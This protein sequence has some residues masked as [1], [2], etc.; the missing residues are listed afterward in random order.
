MRKSFVLF[1]AFASITLYSCK[2]RNTQADE[3]D[4]I[5]VYTPMLNPEHTPKPKRAEMVQRIDTIFLDNS[6]LESYVDNIQQVRFTKDLIFVQA[7][8]VLF[9]FD[10]NGKYVRRILKKG[11]GH[12]EYLDLSK[13]DIQE[14]KELI[15]V[16]DARQGEFLVYTFG[17][18]FVRRF[19]A[20]SFVADFVV[21]PNGHY[22][23]MN[24]SDV[25]RCIR[26]L[27]ETDENG[28]YLRPLYQIPDYFKHISISPEYLVHIN[29]SVIGC[30][31]LEENDYIFHYQNDTL[32]PVYKIKPDI[33]M[34]RDIMEDDRAWDDSEHEYGKASYWETD[35]Y[36]GISLMTPGETYNFMIA[37]Y[38]KQTGKTYRYYLD[39]LM[40]SD[41]QL[42][43]VP[44]FRFCYKGKA[45]IFY[46]Y[47]IISQSEEMMKEFPTITPD[48]NPVLFFTTLK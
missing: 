38:N 30:Q 27:F 34:S 47:D 15:T 20:P 1:L 24:L 35:E 21:L 14:D 17:G 28:E 31:G 23:I 33:V 26:G 9:M 6:V 41:T 2:T 8:D 29:D 39:E 45:I 44:S 12:G 36:M 13:F 19:P 22:L 43:F 18:E 11:R 7:Q 48:S 5:T 16:F 25:R 46:N 32:V 40:E 10:W 37:A 3:F 42:D 4:G